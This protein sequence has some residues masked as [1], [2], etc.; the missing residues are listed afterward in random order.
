MNISSLTAAGSLILALFVTAAPAFG[1]ERE[2]PKPIEESCFVQGPTASNLNSVEELPAD[3]FHIRLKNGMVFELSRTAAG[4][5]LAKT[6]SLEQQMVFFSRR[7]EFLA[8]FVRFL[9]FPRVIGSMTWAKNK[10]RGCFNRTEQSVA[11]D[12]I[13]VRLGESQHDPGQI[14]KMG[15]E[16]IARVLQVLDREIWNDS[17]VFINAKSRSTS[18]IFGAS[19][20]A[21]IPLGGFYKM[22]G[23]QFDFG[24]D[25]EKKEGFFKRHWLKQNFK[26]ALFCFESMLVVGLL[27]QYHLDQD[28][29]QETST[30]VAMPFGFAYRSGSNTVGFGYLTG[31]SLSDLTGAGLIFL[32]EVKTGAAIMSVMKVASLFS[33]Y[34]TETTRSTIAPS[35]LWAS[36]TRHLNRRLNRLKCE[37]HL[38]S[39]DKK[40]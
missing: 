2:P 18:F 20:G 21:A 25:F 14:K 7:K 6:L 26:S 36:L 34:A 15:Y 9:A 33:L 4:I 16:V 27:Q 40:E 3:L 32:G 29:H 12:L 5:E 22:R 17:H 1:A 30:T 38:S 11:E 28:V 37:D 31:L 35:Q 19:A 23:I 39:T 24:Y 10:I 13:Q 8:Q